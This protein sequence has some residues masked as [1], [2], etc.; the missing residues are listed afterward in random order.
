MDPPSFETYVREAKI[1]VNTELLSEVAQ[2]PL[3]PEPGYPFGNPELPSKDTM[4]TKFASADGPSWYEHENTVPLARFTPAMHLLARII[5]Q[6]VWPIDDQPTEM[7]VE[8][9]KFLFAVV[10]EVPIDFCTHAI[11]AMIEAFHDKTNSLPYA[12]L[13]SQIVWHK[14]IPIPDFERTQSAFYFGKDSRQKSLAEFSQQPKR[15]LPHA[16]KVPAPAAGCETGGAS[17][18]VSMSSL[19]KE[20]KALIRMMGNM[21][22]MVKNIDERTAKMEE[23][24]EPRGEHSDQHLAAGGNPN[25]RKKIS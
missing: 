3:V 18:S 25:K 9:A 13:I 20:V 21:E 5:L 16:H 19:M 10:D 8:R 11:V 14:K 2:I 22:K 15:L 23:G 17:S 12:G 4:M 7:G 6:N 1:V 24:Q